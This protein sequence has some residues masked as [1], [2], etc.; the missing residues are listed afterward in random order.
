VLAKP[1]RFTP[2]S[3]GARLPKKGG[4]RHY[5]GDLSTEEVA[6]QVAREYPGMPPPPNTRAHW[7]LTSRWIH[8]VI[9]VVRLLR[10]SLPP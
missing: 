5:G 4:P 2:P 3:H 1:E 8:V 6:A 7:F 10:P 9:T